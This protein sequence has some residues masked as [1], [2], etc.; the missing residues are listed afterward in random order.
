MSLKD[1]VI[2]L[3]IKGRDLF[4]APAK[5]AESAMA[6][7]S[8]KSKALNEQLKSIESRQQAAATLA[9]LGVQATKLTEQINEQRLASE[10]A[11]ASLEKS[12]TALGA[13][14]SEQASAEKQLSKHSAELSK[15]C[16]KLEQQSSQQRLAATEVQR[17]TS[18]HQQA[19]Q[20]LSRLA[21]RQAE[22]TN[23]QVAAEA[24]YRASGNSA[25][26]LRRALND[27]NTELRTVNS[28]V[29]VAESEVNRLSKALDKAATSQDKTT[30]EFAQTRARIT[31]LTASQQALVT[32]TSHTS[33][34]IREQEKALQAQRS[35]AD[36]AKAELR[37]LE[38]ELGKNQRAAQKHAK[39]LHDAE[40]DTKDLTAASHKLAVQ[41]QAAEQALIQTNK[42][43][44]KHQ[45]LL[46]ESKKGAAEFTGSIGGATRSLL[47]M[48][49]AYV[50][51]DRLWDS[52]KSILAT[53]DDYKKLEAQLSSLMGT[54]REGQAATQ[55][56]KEFA[57]STGTQIDTVRESFVLMKSMGLDPMNGSLQALVDYGAK[58]GA[59][60]EKLQGVIL[61]VSQMWAKQKI[62][63]EEAIQ[64]AERGIPVWDMLAQATGKSVA[65]LMKM[66]ENSQLTREHI[67]LL[68]NEMGNAASGQAAD[69][70]RRLGG[71]FNVLRNN[72]EEFK[73]TI[74]DSGVYKVA[75]NFIKEL[76]ERFKAMAEDGSLKQAAQKISDFFSRLITDGGPAIKATLENISALATGVNVVVSSVR[77]AVN[78][79]TAG[80]SSIAGIY[81]GIQAQIL[82]G[83][84]AILDAIGA[85]KIAAKVRQGAEAV[86]A[87][88][89][90]YIAQVEQD[91]KDI[92]A[93]WESMTQGAA[94]S[95][96]RL[97]ES[98]KTSNAEI[99]RDTQA[100]LGQATA[101]T[102]TAVIEQ[103]E[104]L[105]AAAHK[106][107]DEFT[108]QQ[109]AFEQ[110][111]I[112]SEQLAGSFRAMAEAQLRLA[113]ETQTAVP[114]TLQQQAALLGLETSL[115]AAARATGMLSQEQLKAEQ[116]AADYQAQ[117][118]R[119]GITS[120]KSLQEQEAAAKSTYDAV[121]L[122]M[123]QGIGS[124][125]ELEQAYQKWADAA[126]KAATAQGELP[127]E[128]LQTE[129]AAQGFL[130]ILTSMV[131]EQ[132]KFN[133]MVDDSSKLLSPYVSR[134]NEARE[135]ISRIETELKAH[136]VSLARRTQ[137]SKELVYWQ[138]EERKSRE[139]LQ[140]AQEQGLKTSSQLLNEQHLLERQ[141]ERLAAAYGRGS[142]SAGEFA[143]KQ[144]TLTERL[145]I[146]NELLGDFA[147][148]QSQVKQSI[149]AT[150][151]SLDAQSTALQ[152]H[153]QAVASAR[154]FVN[155]FAGAQEHLNK[156][157]D[158]SNTSM[159]DMD[160][161][162]EDLNRSIASNNEVTDGW[163]QMLA[164]QSNAAFERE[165]RIIE[166]TKAYQRMQQ[167]LK[168][169]TLTLAQLKQLS[170]DVT[171]GFQHL[172]QTKLSQLTSSIDEARTRL[173]SLRDDLTGTVH[174]LQVE[175]DQ[176]SNQGKP[177]A[178]MELLE[179]R[180]Q[181]QRKLN[182]ARAMGDE[183][184]Q[185]AAQKA[186]LLAEQIA[187]TKSRQLA[188]EKAQQDADERARLLAE[189]QRAAQT[190]A[191]IA[192]SA[193]TQPLMS[194]A[195]EPDAVLR[196]VVGNTTLDAATSKS[197]LEMLLIEIKRQQQLGS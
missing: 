12:R 152:Q 167:Q 110:G 8:D 82:A 15:L 86:Q 141:L 68:L 14:T 140:F 116:A 38:Q 36:A 37:S 101:E 173:L 193:L 57:N 77:I 66:S 92:K 105:R 184:A 60:Q 43:L 67:R 125:Y 174:S 64:L 61:A 194:A 161:R 63:A 115:E 192:R 171:Y 47:A 155:L 187:A 108:A 127:S 30:T 5:D 76:N 114:E 109:Q 124:A 149:D 84:A 19:Q 52:L 154:E 59:S 13:L 133:A 56:I 176:L 7:L 120:V 165:K 164:Q 33:A 150:N 39:T 40:I 81:T 22:A 24:A 74:A 136:N 139:K 119:A 87:I 185:M 75:T 88:A 26:D 104:R 128:L 48:A 135:A 145:R 183:A 166:E 27:A 3:I 144:E 1:Q 196:L 11:S 42:E 41:Q 162:L 31:E 132:S 32:A 25:K 159:A 51:L 21:L 126:L 69:S 98:I 179:R 113:K 44:T 79:V 46:A 53:G 90:A 170:G 151:G 156:Q 189:Q 186:L 23:Q 157:F 9:A 96:Q 123:E 153:S 100:T 147:N 134:I 85:D 28:E 97:A 121:K 70:L 94:A 65:E 146:V 117:M 142:L 72:W 129:A 20:V 169:N 112:T 177:S 6:L 78:A 182:A 111:L 175:L 137:L 102:T 197:L 181:L 191:G 195:R 130:P 95:H 16:S 106:L 17:L 18:E 62:Q 158:Y 103:V 29:K 89:D 172:D 178:E 168:S 163:W 118:L 138:D 71:Q 73:H 50:G 190:D 2:S 131:L 54:M 188:Q 55:W 107:T 10:R 4:S 148:Q 34:Q 143:L 83:T 35:A 49:G 122:A 99:A 93:A 45:R 80:I 58:V 91:S 160:R 180:N